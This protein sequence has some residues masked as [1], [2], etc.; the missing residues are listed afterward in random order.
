MSI[1]SLKL[2]STSSPLVIA[3]SNLCVKQE[4]AFNVYL[5]PLFILIQYSDKFMHGF[6]FASFFIVILLYSIVM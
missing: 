3:S 6:F 5:P 2:A 4:W 1:R